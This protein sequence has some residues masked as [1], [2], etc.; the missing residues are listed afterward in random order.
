MKTLNALKIQPIALALLLLSCGKPA[1]PPPPDAATQTAE[2]EPD[3]PPVL[4]EEP[5]LHLPAGQTLGDAL[6]P[7]PPLPRRLTTGAQAGALVPQTGCAEALPANCALGKRLELTLPPQKPDDP[8]QIAEVCLCTR[9][10]ERTD[11]DR[12]ALPGK[13]LVAVAVWP[14]DDKTH[15]A[16]QKAELVF[17]EAQHRPVQL[18]VE[19]QKAGHDASAWG[20]L[21]A[22]GWPQVPVLAVA[23]A[24]FYDGT[25]GEQIVWQRTAHALHVADG[26]L[27][28]QPLGART[29]TSLD[30]DHLQTLCEGLGEAAPADRTGTN[31]AACTLREQ[32]AEPHAEA[33]V[34]HLEVRQKRL[35]EQGK[36]NLKGQGKETAENDPDPQSIWLRE[37]KKLLKA[38]QWQKALELALQVDMVCGEAVTEAHAIVLEALKDGQQPLVKTAPNQTLVEVCEPLPDKPAP[39]RQKV[40]AAPAAKVQKAGKVPQASKPKRKQR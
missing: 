18:P 9:A 25:L 27:S 36:D 15:L 34:N 37:A 14:A 17:P 31:A 24:R 22:T 5:P 28:W 12:A 35:K 33:V 30:L 3:P 38:G 29:F 13:Q 26:K 10:T 8:P 32:L 7:I 4:Q 16:E 20:T 40:E 39:K 11:Q 6:Q 23:S 21:I 19:R 1:T 2:K